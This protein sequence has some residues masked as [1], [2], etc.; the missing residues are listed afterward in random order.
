MKKAED[1]S[2]KEIR[3]EGKKLLKKT[4]EYQKQQGITGYRLMLKAEKKCLTFKGKPS[5][6]TMAFSPEF[7]D[8]HVF[9]GRF[10]LLPYF[11]E[12]QGEV[13]L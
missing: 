13:E 2:W 9:S 5:L 11:M 3:R 12:I 8:A 6:D 7:N 4:R 1:M 10:E